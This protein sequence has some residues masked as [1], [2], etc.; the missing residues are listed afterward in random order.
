ME[1]VYAAL[2]NVQAV[3]FAAL[4]VLG[5][6]QWRRH[7]SRPSAWLAATFAVL[8]VAVLA[9]RLIPD[10]SEGGT[11]QLLG[12]FV[13][14]VLVVFPY[15]LV[16]FTAAFSPLPR[17]LEVIAAGLT[18]ASVA[19]AF[20]VGDLAD[21]GEPRSSALRAYVVL[22]LANWVFLTAM[23]TWRLW[24]GGRTAPAVARW[25][26]R[27]LALGAASLALAIVGAGTADPA[28]R[29]TG[30]QVV[31]QVL[32]LVS[33]L[34]FVLGF[35]PPATLR[36]VWRRRGEAALRDVERRLAEG[37]RTDSEIARLLLPHAVSLLGGHGAVLLDDTGA[38][39]GV[40]GLGRDEVDDVVEVAGRT[41]VSD[42]R[43]VLAVEMRAGVLA[44]KASPYTPF[45]G[46]DE[47]AL[48]ERLATVADL[49]MARSQLF[50]QLIEA[51][52][53]A[54]MGSFEWH[55]ATNRLTWSEEMYRLYGVD[56]ATFEV[57]Y[58]NVAA[59]V[60]PEARAVGEKEL[61][62]AI[63]EGRAYSYEFAVKTPDG[64]E[65]ILSARGNVVADEDGRPVKLIGTIQDVTDRKR[66]EQFRDRFIA[67]AAHELRTPI[68][69]LTG[70]VDLLA[71]T[72][73]SLSEE[74]YEQA[75]DAMQRAG[76]R[77]T[78]LV[79]N[80]LDLS[81]IQEGRL[82]VRAGLVGVGD[83][84]RRVVAAHP[85]PVGVSVS[86]DVDG[87]PTV[88][89]D[90]DRL[91]QALSNLLVNAF[92]YGGPNVVIATEREGSDVIVSVSDDGEGVEPELVPQLFEAFTRGSRASTVG[93]SGLGLAI[94]KMVVD[95]TGGEIYYEPNEPRGA[96]FC[97]KFPAA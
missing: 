50:G 11:A 22:V 12:Q 94:V 47:V 58:E 13:I 14:A 74:Q 34:L 68:A 93:G 55:L 6:A 70:F 8:A 35:A 19:G 53:I 1:D 66:E 41:G 42:R 91:D 36:A 28:S 75:M 17:S 21:P 63:E 46:E 40:H 83:I 43:D 18:A 39:V 9:G 59:L 37:V 95:A 24:T 25:R 20:F 89:A 76:R 48:V 33:A 52:R 67:N 4:G 92:R 29:V 38:A 77:A 85:P 97:I 81:R 80:L 45:F 51:Q 79:N 86:V 44:V 26:M 31:V 56:P 82:T 88:V 60:D 30:G 71:A 72:G 27:T 61:A 23:V 5:F 49:A 3:A 96:R 7:A 2:Q 15:L 10:P 73:P 57:T 84:V 32:A 64:A 87:E 78:T 69:T 54:R 65:A 90:P 62:A 16:R